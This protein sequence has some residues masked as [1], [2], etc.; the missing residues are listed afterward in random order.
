M[1]IA[2][3]LG[4]EDPGIA[5][6]SDLGQSGRMASVDLCQKPK[7]IGGERARACVSKVTRTHGQR[8]TVGSDMFLLRTRAHPDCDRQRRT[9]LA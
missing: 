9:R 3:C 7:N 5:T 1:A 4:I 2:Q 8:L 6:E